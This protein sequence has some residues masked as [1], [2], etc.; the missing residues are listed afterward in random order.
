MEWDEFQGMSVTSHRDFESRLRESGVWT[1]LSS[2]ERQFLSFPA[3]HASLDDAYEFSWATE[4]LCCIL[5]ALQQVH[6]IPP[7]DLPVA[8]DIVETLRNSSSLQEPPVLRDPQTLERAR[9]VA[10]LWHWRCRTKFLTDQG[11]FPPGVTA[12]DIARAIA[13]AASAAS[14]DGVI[15]GVLD[16]DL[17]VFGRPYRHVNDEQYAALTSIAVERHRALNWLCGLSPANDWDL[18]PTPT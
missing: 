9:S 16:G 15:A 12:E 4:S 10:E 3:W 17:P 13:N 5:W 6:A 11:R 14:H 8:P 18:T 7:W 1:A 2:K